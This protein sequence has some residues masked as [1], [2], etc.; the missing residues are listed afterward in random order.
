MYLLSRNNQ[1]NKNKVHC[2]YGGKMDEG[3]YQRLIEIVNQ[4][5]NK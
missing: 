1:N 2:A 4:L 5:K 3:E